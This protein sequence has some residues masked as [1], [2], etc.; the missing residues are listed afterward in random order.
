MLYSCARNA[1]GPKEKPSALHIEPRALMV[2]FVCPPGVLCALPCILL[3]LGIGKPFPNDGGGCVWKSLGSPTPACL[4]PVLATGRI[5]SR[6]QG[7]GS[8]FHVNWLQ[9]WHHAAAL[10]GLALL[11]WCFSFLAWQRLLCARC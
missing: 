5:P 7:V 4:P 10:V 3:L 1:A 11:W 2:F 9:I 6:T 8:G